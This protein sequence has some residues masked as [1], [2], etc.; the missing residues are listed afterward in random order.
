MNSEDAVLII[1]FVA[2]SIAWAVFTVAMDAEGAGT[3]IWEPFDHEIDEDPVSNFGGGGVAARGPNNVIYRVW[4]DHDYALYISYTSD[5][6]TTWPSIQIID[7]AWKGHTDLGLGG[8]VILA[9]NTTLVHFTTSDADD[10]YNSY[11]ACRWDWSG[12]WE[13]IKVYGGIMDMTRPKM[14]VNETTVLLW[15][16]YDTDTPK[17]K[18]FDPITKVVEPDEGSPP[19]TW[20][21]TFNGG[22]EDYDITVNQSGYFILCHRSW[23]GS[24]YQFHIRDFELTHDAIYATVGGSTK[25]PYGVTIACTSDD[26]F[27]VG[28]V[29]IYAGINYYGL[30]IWHGDTPWGVMPG[31]SVQYVD[32]REVDK[33]SMGSCINDDDLITF[34]WANDTGGGG[35]TYISKMTGYIDFDDEEWEAAI[36]NGVYDY[37]TD[38]DEWFATTWYDCKY[39]IVEGYSVNIPNAGWMGHHTWKN[40]VGSPDD[41]AFALYWNA[42]FHWYDWSPPDGPRGDDY[43]DTTTTESPIDMTQVG[44]LWVLLAVTA[45]L[46]C[47]ARTYKM[48]IYRKRW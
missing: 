7:S 19:A 46:V 33:Y 10:T 17:H 28:T 13:I 25:V 31:E 15:Y 38:D 24:T 48:H 18:T 41:Y 21:A 47:L 35:D 36:V 6:G 12:S 4:Q 5:N 45:A 9:N 29:V 16:I 3:P 27:V 8:I 39:P 34:Y 30:M 42:S 2:A 11:L 40:E 1:F 37:G 44:E 23:S 32:T 43:D 20:I 14:A 22:P 26:L